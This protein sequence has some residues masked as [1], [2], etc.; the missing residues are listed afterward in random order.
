MADYN[1][2]LKINPNHAN[3]YYS[4]GVTRYILGD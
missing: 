4:R 2:A 3:A 1:A